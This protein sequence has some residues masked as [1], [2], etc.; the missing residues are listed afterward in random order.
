M[1]RKSFKTKLVAGLFLSFA[2]AGGVLAALTNKQDKAISVSAADV[3]FDSIT[4][5]YDD[6]DDYHYYQSPEATAV[7]Y[8]FLKPERI[9]N[10]P[11]PDYTIATL[12]EYSQSELA[13]DVTYAVTEYTGSQN[14]NDSYQNGQTV[15]LSYTL[16]KNDYSLL[17]GFYTF[18]NICCQNCG[19]SYHASLTLAEDLVEDQF[20]GS[21]DAGYE[22]L[23][24]TWGGSDFNYRHVKI[25]DEDNKYYYAE[26]QY[27]TSYYNSDDGLYLDCVVWLYDYQSESQEDYTVVFEYQDAVYAYDDNDYYYFE[28]LNCNV[29][30]DTHTDFA[31]AKSYIQFNY[32]PDGEEKSG[33][34]YNGQ[35]SLVYYLDNETPLP[36][37][38]SGVTFYDYGQDNLNNMIYLIVSV[39]NDGQP[40]I[41]NYLLGLTCA[42]VN[43][44]PN[45]QYEIEGSVAGE[46]YGE[47]IQTL[48][49]EYVEIDTPTIL[50]GYNYLS[51]VQEIIYFTES[52]GRVSGLEY[53]DAVKNGSNI[54]V[55][56]SL[57]GTTG[58]TF[59]LSAASYNYDSELNRYDLTGYLMLGNI[60]QIVTIH[61]PILRFSEDPVEGW[62]Y[63]SENEALV[64]Y[65]PINPSAEYILT[66]FTYNLVGQEATLEY[67][68]DDGSM[69]PP[70]EFAT[71]SRASYDPDNN[72]VTGNFVNDEITVRIGNV[73]MTESF[74]DEWNYSYNEKTFIYY[75]AS[76]GKLLTV[77]CSDANFY[78]GLNAE[79]TRAEL[80]YSINEE[81]GDVQYE[82][83]ETYLYN[84]TYEEVV[85]RGNSYYLITGDCM[86]RDV[87]FKA[88]VKVNSIEIPER[89]RWE[90]I[91][92]ELVYFDERYEEA[93]L[94][95][96][97]QFR[98]ATYDERNGTVEIMYGFYY[99]DMDGSQQ[100]TLVFIQYLTAHITGVEG[101]EGDPEEE[102]YI[103]GSCVECPEPDV[104]TLVLPS[105]RI[106]N[107]IE[108]APEEESKVAEDI[109][110]I[111]DDIEAPQ[112]VRDTIDERIDE[113]PEETGQQIVKTVENTLSIVTTEEEKEI[114][115]TVLGTSV[116]VAANKEPSVT[117]S[118]EV[119]KSL[120]KDSGIV[121]LGKTVDDFYELQLDYLLGRRAVPEK[122]GV[123][124]RG[125]E[126]GEN[127]IDL[128][129][130]KEEYE[131]MVD[132]IDDSVEHMQGAAKQIRQC[133]GESVKKNV[134]QYITV[135]T[136]SSFRNFDEAKANREFVQAVYKA[137]LLHMQ[138]QV[139]QTLEEGHK[140]PYS[141][142]E[143]E[144]QFQDELKACKDIET[145]EEIVLEVL[146]N[147]YVELTGDNVSD[148][149]AF[150]RDVYM[151][152]F[153]AW[154]LDKSLDEVDPDLAAR[155]VKITLEELTTATIDVT[156]NRAKVLEPLHEIT[157][158]EQTF[159][160]AFV[161]GSV[162]LLGISIALPLI[163][164]RRKLQGVAK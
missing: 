78:Q 17:N 60:E 163:L 155:G 57:D 1:I 112:E 137:I 150:K 104:M 2:L 93:D 12:Y 41:N 84:A 71:L 128:S 103:S 158:P 27:N 74:G 77:E 14:Y 36:V 144:K 21:Q 147:K 146:R 157:K 79:Y 100:E 64:Y 32:D 42:K 5:V 119:Y 72:K 152:I 118:T 13:L 18:T 69:Q 153:E 55:T 85:T 145:F 90:Y 143:A 113:V 124:K 58:N 99:Y 49:T 65:D 134:N 23:S 136:E 122:R 149:K 121:H 81:G 96:T 61:S 131:Q 87:E 105:M 24:W 8:Y 50:D 111:L 54:N 80:K 135:V 156:T 98:K 102:V 73:P 68:F 62:N 53:T 46:L 129:V 40:V 126:T 141:N 89:A 162:G 94:R 44:Y 70:R 47:E 20:S 164:K 125:I 123:P 59:Q 10:A 110:T 52:S 38:I 29:C 6:V 86:F 43:N 159:L 48:N 139:I 107:P 142:L 9:Q 91:D 160:I 63:D 26:P 37:D 148:I 30:Q 97:N 4:W 114:V 82:D 51:L 45:E 67:V 115:V 108:P 16:S 56:Y 11:D 140:Q 95:T 66:S 33:F 7:K 120:P 28:T 154:A 3:D 39:E 130:Q 22:D 138:N 127:V 151:K 133:S 15:Q 132:F 92:N 106:I 31:I 116:V 101:Y 88:T 75:R 35:D 19:D 109:N 76:D 161:A 25:I 117:S 34:A 83:L